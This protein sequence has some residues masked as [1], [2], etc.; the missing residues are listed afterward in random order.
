MSEPSFVRLNFSHLLA[1]H[2]R[3]LYG[4][5]QEDSDSRRAFERGG[6]LCFTLSLPR[7][8]GATEA[9]VSVRSDESGETRT[10]PLA[11]GG[12]QGADDLWCGELDTSEMGTGLYFLRPAFRGMAGEGSA[13][14]IAGSG[15]RFVSG[16]TGDYTFQLTL[17]HFRYAE[18][19][20]MRGGI[21]YQIFVDRFARGADTP[22]REDAIL[23]PDWENGMP[24]YP[25][26][27]GAP[28]ANNMFF[29][30]NLQGVTRKLDYL[31]SFG[32]T[33][34]Y[35]NPIFEAYSN[36]KYDTGNYLKID[37]MFGGEDAF[38]ELIS[39]IK[40]RGMHLILDGVFNHTGDDSVYFN[41]YGRYPTLGAYQ[42]KESPYYEWF[43]FQNYPD[44]YTCWWNI[45]ILPR[46]NTQVPSCRDFFLGEGGVID[47]YARRGVDGFRLDVVDEY[48]DG[49][50]SG[51]KERLAASAPDSILYGEV[52]EDASNKIAYGYRRHYF[53][54]EQ[55]DG[56][57]NYELRDG[58]I[59][60]L[61][62]HDPEKLRY[63]LTEVMPNTPHRVQNY[64]MNLLGTHDTV[65][66]LTAL[67]GEEP[68]G[69]TTKEL[70][71]MRMTEEQ[72]TL[73][74]RRLR[75]A[76]LMLVTLPGI[77]TIYY[78]DEAGSEGYAD[79]FN[80]MPYPWHHTDEDLLAF[81]RAVGAL[82][83]SRREY[84]EGDFRLLHLDSDTAAFSRTLGT[85]RS[86]TLVNG[87]DID[88]TFV[89]RGVWT[90]GLNP[91][92]SITD[93]VTLP[94]LAARV[95]LSKSS[96]KQRHK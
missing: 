7:Q 42:S 19:T 50:V 59:R 63:A 68:A 61:R 79:P 57:M 78:G 22:V 76:Y 75:L 29:G 65:R 86:L 72:R 23:N 9:S 40:K 84:A 15:C 32:V 48:P 30:G 93:R 25:A 60:F 47:R 6:V 81:Y 55:L 95:L 10:V 89:V 17:Y 44:K 12:I 8:L 37:E 77:P 2:G 71:E 49:F 20:W 92:E 74:V 3:F 87:S 64:Q 28:L 83:H 54:G 14:K 56:V 62:Y 53:Q 41:R 24:Q 16:L 52:W 36:H 91:G 46:I 70:A 58:I 88:K 94:P 4:D 43:D 82:R 33:C 96:R 67:A 13:L 1:C 38:D 66:I 85:A 90:D 11:W 69:H 18:P 5:G 27:P 45:P 34:L 21:L 80:R 39:E 26:Y 73:A 35:L 31:A 51:L